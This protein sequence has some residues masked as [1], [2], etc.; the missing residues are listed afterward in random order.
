MSMG[1][2]VCY[3]IG[4]DKHT[5]ERDFG[6][7]ASVLVDV[8]LS[9]PIRNPIW[10]EEEEGISFVQDIEVVKMPKFCGHCK[11]VGHLVVECKVL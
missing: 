9:K 8:D 10:V 2:T 5:L 7:Y 3:P 11:S 1:K 6:Y 4:V